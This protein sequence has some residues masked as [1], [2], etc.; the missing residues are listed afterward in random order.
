MNS[1]FI[2][3]VYKA[4]VCDVPLQSLLWKGLHK[5][6]RRS[7]LNEHFSCISRNVERCL[8]ALILLHL[9]MWRGMLVTKIKINTGDEHGLKRDFSEAEL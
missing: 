4:P 9:F 5:S 8:L 3:M 1:S 7:V 2:S 6:L